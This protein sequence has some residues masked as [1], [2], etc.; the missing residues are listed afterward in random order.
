MQFVVP[1]ARD[2]AQIELTSVQIPFVPIEKFDLPPREIVVEFRHGVPQRLLRFV[3]RNRFRHGPDAMLVVFQSG[4]EISG[5]R[6]K[7]IV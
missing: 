2:A 4:L 1:A 6:F 3:L 5:C 7:K